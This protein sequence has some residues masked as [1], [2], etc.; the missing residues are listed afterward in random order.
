MFLFGVWTLW[1][2]R[3]KVVFQHKTHIVTIH[4]EIM[5]RAVE[6]SYCAQKSKASTPRISV[7]LR[8]EKTQQNWY[9]LNTN[10]AS[11]GNPSTSGGGGVI[12]N[13]EDHGIR[14][15]SRNIGT[16]TSLIAEIWALRD[17]LNL[18]ISMNLEAVEI[19]V[20][21]KSIV[22]L[23]ANDNS[24]DHFITSLVDDCRTMAFPNSP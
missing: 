13:E 20:D 24:T 22:D 19:E 7:Q 18:C 21:A 23:V 1:Q 15:F 2:H 8:W 10:R 14:G 3:N 5:H 4:E 6:C 9:K 11:L 17:W 12:R 16:T